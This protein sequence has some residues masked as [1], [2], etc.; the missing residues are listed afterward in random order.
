V[1]GLQVQQQYSS[2]T[3]AAAADKPLS[4]STP[5]NGA[6]WLVVATSQV[7]FGMYAHAH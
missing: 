3:A 4:A 2:N 1:D 5:G 7:C 6:A